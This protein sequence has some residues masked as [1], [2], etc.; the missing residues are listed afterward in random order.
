MKRTLAVLGL[1]AFPSLL[2]ADEVFLR[3]GGVIRGEVVSEG[4]DSI[5]VEVGPGRITLPR[6]RVE[7]VVLSISDLTAYRQRAAALAARDVQGWLSLARWA[8]ERDLLTQAREAYGRAAAADPSN[9]EAQQ[10]LGRVL[11]DGHWL[12]EDAANRARGLVEFEGRWLS[13]AERTAILEARAA[14]AQSRRADAE[15]AAR[16]REAEARADAA[17]AEARRLDAEARAAD[18]GIP[19]DPF[20]GG[21]VILVPVERDHRSGHD[22][23]DRRR[24]HDHPEGPP[25]KRPPT[26]GW[27]NQPERPAPPPAPPRPSPRRSG[28]GQDDRQR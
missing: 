7:R 5:V 13:V 4:R 20:G 16:I 15:A 23:R 28:M 21:G 9:A 19:Y 1:L 8:E 24:R 11:V 22:G 14:D 26:S 18:G 27:G 10:G 25:A 17:E 6:S 2:G 3:G 12:S